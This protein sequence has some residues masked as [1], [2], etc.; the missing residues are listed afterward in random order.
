MKQ[1]DKSSGKLLV[2][3]KKWWVLGGVLSLAI[4]T[5]GASS[6]LW[7]PLLTRDDHAPIVAAGEYKPNTLAARYS[8]PDDEIE[9]EITEELIRA[10][11]LFAKQA[12]GTN[13]VLRATEARLVKEDPHL[14]QA[15]RDPMQTPLLP[16]SGY[17]TIEQRAAQFLPVVEYL[18]ADYDSRQG[19]Q[20]KNDRLRGALETELRR[21]IA[22]QLR[23]E[24]QQTILDEAYANGN[25]DPLLLYGQIISAPNKSVERR[26]AYKQAVDAIDGKPACELLK[27]VIYA[28]SA[29]YDFDVDY[30]DMGFRVID[31]HAVFFSMIEKFAD[32]PPFMEFVLPYLSGY[33]AMGNRHAEGDFALKIAELPE[34]DLPVWVRNYFAHGVTHYLGGKVWNLRNLWRNTEKL[35]PGV[36]KIT[37]LRGQLLVRAWCDRPNSVR[38]LTR[39]IEEQSLWGST[40]RPNHHWFRLALRV[41]CDDP[42]VYETYLRQ[43]KPVNVGS[44]DD[45]MQIAALCANCTQQDTAIPYFSTFFLDGAFSE[46]SWQTPADS[47]LQILMVASKVLDY[48]RT[49]ASAEARGVVAADCFT[50]IA[51]ILWD[52]GRYEDVAW[53]LENEPD[54]MTPAACRS[55]FLDLELLRSLL[56]VYD[57]RTKLLCQQLHQRVL[58]HG[59]HQNATDW[60]QIGHDLEA[61]EEFVDDQDNLFVKTVRQCHQWATTFHQGQWVDLEINEDLIGWFVRDYEVE[62][63]D[64]GFVLSSSIKSS[65][66]VLRP[67]L[68]FPM[69][70]ELELEVELLDSDTQDPYGIALVAGP[71]FHEDTV[72]T[73]GLGMMVRFQPGSWRFELTRPRTNQGGSVIQAFNTDG[74]SKAQMRMEVRP[75]GVEIFGNLE[76]L[77]TVEG[78][79]EH[80]GI[81]QIGRWRQVQLFYLP[82]VSVRYHVKR[83]RVRQLSDPDDA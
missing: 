66:D 6:F 44:A 8:V 65:E 3:K 50:V 24:S 70:L 42:D 16:D 5:I 81:I 25:R 14:R 52:C 33:A 34:E 80:E 57:D 31:A 41:V 55:Y 79:T 47:D 22:R 60:K 63:R 2:G 83:F 20:P 12:E 26:A 40:G 58:S 46:R 71:M 53:L 37:S 74:S 76:S 78:P 38:L 77:R 67:R 9:V 51:K 68:H 1:N 82:D 18:M 10:F 45:A 59:E 29:R 39:L 32:K 54:S 7:L 56:A 73:G 35:P 15:L 11:E 43:M 30:S 19:A 4:V 62:E 36:D 23:L 49:M 17:P 72:D 48:R 21:R 28:H 69:P 13:E 27:F 75:S 64:D 61:L